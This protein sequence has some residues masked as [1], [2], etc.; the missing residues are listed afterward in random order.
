MGWVYPQY[1]EFRPWLICRIWVVSLKGR[2][3][4][5]TNISGKSSLLKCYQK[6]PRFPNVF[7]D[8]WMVCFWGPNT[9]SQGVW[10]PR[11]WWNRTKHLISSWFDLFDSCKYVYVQFKSCVGYAYICLWASHSYVTV[12]VFT[13]MFLVSKPS[14]RQVLRRRAVARG[15]GHDLNECHPHIPKDPC[16]PGSKLPLFC[17]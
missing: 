16:V 5:L 8:V 4:T 15:I 12:C 3:Q 1:K 10:K 17:V 13:Q 14:W 7:Q 6:P 11:D 2:T 9:S